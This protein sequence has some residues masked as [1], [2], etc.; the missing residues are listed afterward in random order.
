MTTEP[1]TPADCDLTDFP[2]MFID[3]RRLL[4]SETWIEAAEHPRLGH[5]LMCLW[6]ESWHQRPA[7]SLP[8][9][10]AVLARL[11]MCD[12]KTWRKLRD[13]ALEG[14]VKCSDGRWYHPVVAEKALEAWERKQ[15]FRNRTA[16]AREARHAKRKTET[17]GASTG[18]T[19]EDVTTP[20]TVSVTETRGTGTGTGRGTVTVTASA[21]AAAVTARPQQPQQSAP[22]KIP[23]PEDWQPSPADLAFVQQNTLAAPWSAEKLRRVIHEFV[24]HYRSRGNLSADWSADFR[25]WVLRQPRFEQQAGGNEPDEH[26]FRDPILRACAADLGT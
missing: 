2:S 8:D 5:V 17:V 3:V 21:N 13:M 9:N 25:R 20:V 1:L 18:D 24:A 16:K 10:D 7:A 19:T 15:A 12:L 14:W 6:M 4:T 23:I 11:A 26:G 22:Q